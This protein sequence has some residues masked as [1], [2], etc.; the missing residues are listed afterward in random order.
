M[1]ASLEKYIE[2]LG[3]T[4]IFMSFGLRLHLAKLD[5]AEWIHLTE[6]FCVVRQN[7]ILEFD[8]DVPRLIVIHIL[9]N[10]KVL[11]FTSPN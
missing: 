6:H 4:S 1:G 8:Q 3:T 10:L 5:E 11:I 7:G 2:H 9:I